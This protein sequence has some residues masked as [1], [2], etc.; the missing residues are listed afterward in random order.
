[1]IADS[2]VT[3]IKDDIEAMKA[4]ILV[5]LSDKVLTQ[6]ERNSNQI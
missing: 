6:I 2:R 1:M 3:D 5:H 4:N